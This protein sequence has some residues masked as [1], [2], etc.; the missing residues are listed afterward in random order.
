MT[1]FLGKELIGGVYWS[2]SGKRVDQGSLL[3]LGHLLEFIWYCR[4]L[5]VKINIGV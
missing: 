5:E 1:L 3:E 4:T 2:I